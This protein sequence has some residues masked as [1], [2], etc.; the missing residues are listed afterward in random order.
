MGHRYVFRVPY[1]PHNGPIEYV[2]NMVQVGLSTR[3]HRIDNDVQLQQAVFDI[4]N[5]IVAFLPYFLF[6][7]FR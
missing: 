3:M 7:G 2:F 4:F 1:N 5:A 6:V